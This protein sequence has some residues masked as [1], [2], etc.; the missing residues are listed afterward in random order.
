[1]QGFFYLYTMILHDFIESRIPVNELTEVGFL[2]KGAT[3]KE[4][5]ERI[6]W[7]FSLKNIFLYDFIGDPKTIQV[8][9]DI[10]TFSEN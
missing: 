2:Q 10:K 7:Y 9:A 6:C 1:M 5:A 3:D 8:K 4:I